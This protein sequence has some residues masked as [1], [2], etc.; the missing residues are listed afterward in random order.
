[1]LSKTPVTQQATLG[2]NYLAVLLPEGASLF[3]ISAVNGTTPDKSLKFELARPSDKGG[4]SPDTIPLLHELQDGYRSKIF[5]APFP[6]PLDQWRQV[7]VTFLDCLA[8]DGL[9]VAVSYYV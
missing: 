8:D 1:M 3:S 6:A 2:T 9:S 4:E 7:I 5:L